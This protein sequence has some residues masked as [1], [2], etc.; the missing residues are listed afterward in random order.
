MWGATRQLDLN[1]LLERQNIVFLI[2]V[3]FVLLSYTDVST[4]KTYAAIVQLL[5]GLINLCWENDLNVLV[6]CF[7]KHMLLY[8][9][10]NQQIYLTR[11]YAYAYA[12]KS[13]ILIILQTNDFL[14]YNPIILSS[15]EN[16]NTTNSSLKLKYIRIL[17]LG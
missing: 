13:S 6:Y 5:F 16:Y 15:K 17:Q 8:S 12:Y 14:L 10:K 2:K 11:F 1:S 4:R 9:M 3:N 7:H